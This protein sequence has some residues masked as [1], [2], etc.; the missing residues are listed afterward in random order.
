M[1]ILWNVGTLQN[2]LSDNGLYEFKI[3][4]V[5]FWGTHS[6][7]AEFGTDYKEEWQ[8]STQSGWQNKL[9]ELYQEGWRIQQVIKGIT[10]INNGD[11]NTVY[12]MKRSIG[13]D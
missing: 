7:S 8:S 11:I 3:F 9:N 4:N 12:I 6:A 13:E 10:A 2:A 1:Q 5:R